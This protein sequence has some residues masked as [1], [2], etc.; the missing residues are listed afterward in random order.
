MNF[1]RNVSFVVISN[2]YA[3]LNSFPWPAVDLMHHYECY[4]V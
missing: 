2:N 4:S 3:M 1:Y